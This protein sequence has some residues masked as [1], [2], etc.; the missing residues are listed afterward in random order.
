MEEEEAVENLKDYGSTEDSK[1]AKNV[2]KHQAA[3]ELSKRRK[4]LLIFS[5]MGGEGFP[6]RKVVPE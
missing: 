2:Q 5:L 6:P 1:K 4:G 3:T